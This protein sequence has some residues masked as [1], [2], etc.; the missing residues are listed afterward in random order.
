MISPKLEALVWQYR[1]LLTVLLVVLVIYLCEF[2]LL[3]YKYSL[4]TGG[5][6]QPVTYQTSRERLIFAALSLWFDV[7]CYGLF[8]S[9]WFW[10]ADKLNKHGVVVYYYF[11]VFFGT[12]FGVWFNLKF[13]VLSYFSDT[14]NLQIIKNLGGGS[15]KEALFYASNEIALF[16]AILCVAGLI[17]AWV[18]NVIRNSRLL[19]NWA[20]KQGGHSCYTLRALIILVL[21]TPFVSLFVEENHFYRYGLQKKTSYQIVSNGLDVLSDFDLDGFGNFAFPR[22]KELFNAQVYPGALD[23]PNDGIDQDGYLGDA[24]TFFEGKDGLSELAPKPGKN[25]VLIVL[26]TARADVLTKFFNNRYVAPVMRELAQNGTHFPYAYS[27]TG[28]TTTSI[29][30]ILNRQLVN[31]KNKIG[32]VDF[33]KQAGYQLSVLSAQDESFGDVAHIV[34]MDTP[35]VDYFDAKTAINDRVFPSTDA[36]SLRLSEERIIRQFKQRIGEVDFAK[37]QF[38]YINIQ[39]G[40]FPYAYPGMREIITHRIIPRTEIKPENKDWMA[41]TYWNAMANADWAIGEI[42]NSLKL[43]GIY[44]N[45]TLVILGDHGESLFDDGFLGHG[46][47]FNDM[48][49]KIPLIINDPNITIDE[50]VPIGQEDVAEIAVRSALQQEQAKHSKDKVIFQIIGKLEEPIMCAHVTQKGQRVIFDFRS[51]MFFFSELNRWKSYDDVLKDTRL[52]DKASK[53]LRHWEALRWQQE[54]LVL[55]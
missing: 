21:L 12:I 4:F 49:T 10:I 3:H 52:K 23:I 39:A 31:N 5:F 14:I 6:L 28:Y 50:D 44:E 9:L 22:D 20:K 43:A 27:H 45:T 17:I 34:G 24:T 54:G 26:E 47:A 7:V 25:I 36:G 35:G 30:A 38:F 48:Q 55:H 33:L 51:D 13:K 2:I 41:E 53:L 40:H 18:L 11:I 32:L 8:A 15:L 46:H 37:P 29:I 1:R 42:V 19:Q 16:G